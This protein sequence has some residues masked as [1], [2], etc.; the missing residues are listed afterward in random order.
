MRYKMVVV[1]RSDLRITQGKAA[2]QASHASVTCALEAK[3]NTPKWFKEWY[4]EGQKKVVLKTDSLEE[5]YDMRERARR[6]G[7][8]SSLITDAGLTEIPPGTITCLGIGPGPEEM[9]DS[10]TGDL[11]LF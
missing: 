8:A 11:P 1:M 9:L 2:A 4:G 10:I 3:K 5:L 7:L 6:V